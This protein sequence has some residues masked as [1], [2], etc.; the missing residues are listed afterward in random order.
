[1]NQ[2]I[3]LNKVRKAVQQVKKRQQADENAVK[4]GL[5]KAERILQATRDEKMR[6]RLDQHRFEDDDQ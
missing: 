5:T 3:N 2:P 6:T 4:F 1:M